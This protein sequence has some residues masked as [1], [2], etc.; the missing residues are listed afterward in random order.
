MADLQ[1]YIDGKNVPPPDNWQ[2]TSINLSFEDNSPDA[3]VK[4]IV[5]EWLGT[6]AAILNKWKDQGLIGGFGLF[7]G[8]AFRIEVCNPAINVF[9]G[10]IDMTSNDTRFT[11]DKVTAAVMETN[12]VPSFTKQAE[13]VSFQY[14]AST[15]YAGAGKITKADYVPVPY[16]LSTLPDYAQ[17]A[18]LTVSLVESL[19]ALR[20]AFVNLTNLLTKII[21]D[22]AGIYT[23]LLVVGDAIM[24]IL[25]LIYFIAMILLVIGIINMIVNNFIQPVKYKYGMRVNTLM[26]RAAAS[27][28]YG[29]SST[30][31]R[32]ST[33]SNLVI[34][35]KKQGYFNDTTFVESFFTKNFSRKYYDDIKNPNAYGYYEGNFAELL[36]DMEDVFNAKIVIRNQVLYFERW[37]YWNLQ[38]GF[39]VP[40]I[41]SEAPFM[42]PFGTNASELA[43][44]Y[45]VH[46][47]L[48]NMDCNTYDE[49]EGTSTQMILV[50]ITVGKQQNVLL[51]GLTDKQLAFALVKRKKVLKGSEKIVNFVFNLLYPF[52]IL[53]TAI[54][55]AVAYIT[56][57][58]KVPVLP[59]NPL[60]ARVGFMM[61]CS[62]FTG[63]PKLLVVD[64]ADKV[65]VNND[66]YTSAYT[67]QTN[68][69]SASWA[70]NG[71]TQHN[72]YLIYA[73][74]DIPLCCS[75]FKK[76]KDN[77]IVKDSK[78]RFG[79]IDSIDWNPHLE[80]ATINFRVKEKFTINLTQSILRDGI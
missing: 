56:G 1:F 35:P 3:S 48:D 7:E 24:I 29:F 78:Q 43:A 16:V 9:D 50:P 47:S 67:L 32:G 25:Y 37:D 41:S 53:G 22:L 6:N 63:M 26:T 33:Y 54:I 20:H 59:L 66:T 13:A 44:N 17:V 71:L 4:T 2:N 30:I 12:R 60:N 8:P 57:A 23:I 15:G 77:N 51:H 75:D 49:Y 39:I 21:N 40:A 46:Y 5:Y 36:R 38:S 73:G 19:N 70:I 68:Y 52:Y 69:H 58:Q 55:N 65:H 72:Q 14:L 27:M 31:L 34:I 80:K 62:D 79:R 42:D 64:G 61:L 45:L 10:C 28:G 74:K 76:I 18:I 11:C